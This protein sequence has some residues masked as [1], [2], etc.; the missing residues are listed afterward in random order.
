MWGVTLSGFVTYIGE[1]KTDYGVIECE[2]KMNLQN[3]IS[4]TKMLV[5]KLSEPKWDRQTI[6]DSIKEE[7]GEYNE[8]RRWIK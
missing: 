4:Y 2:E 7:Q 5:Y 8:I 1:D 3:G 6:E